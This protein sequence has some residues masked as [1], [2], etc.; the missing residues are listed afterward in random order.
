MFKTPILLMIFNRP[1]YSF[2]TFESIRKA[3]PKQLFIA[4]DGARKDKTGEKQI[5]EKLRKDIISKVDWKC[6]VKT[7]FRKEN[8]GC[9][10]AVSGAITWFF[11]NV[12]QGIILEDDC[13]PN[14]SFYPFCEFMLER[15]KDD[16]RIS[17]IS[18]TS[19]I[20]DKA[21]NYYKD[22]FFSKY[23][24]IWGW[25]TWRRSWNKLDLKM[26]DWEIYKDNN[27]LYNLYKN[28][29]WA[30][31]FTK[32]FN[33]GNK[34]NSWGI[35]WFYTCVFENTLS[36][37]PINNLISNVGDIG[38]HKEEEGS[39]PFIKRKTKEF[40]TKNIRHPKQVFP[41]RYLNNLQFNNLIEYEKI[42]DSKSRLK[43]FLQL[44]FIS[45]PLERMVKKLLRRR[46]W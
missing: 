18:G 25:A 21:Q 19:Y 8:L 28:D 16:T 43:H 31:R 24:S 30:R 33:I 9:R 46:T 37:S 7:L 26:K 45:K 36:I 35:P 4:S 15:Y 27:E 12:E 29:D 22:Y 39:D 5:V 3:K 20:F 14:Q 34:I 1:E 38:T 41:S 40:D 32:M 23:Y 11:K 44:R 13:V 17:M 2:Q 42:R 6:E 10:N